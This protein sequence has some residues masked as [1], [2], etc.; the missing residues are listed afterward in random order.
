MLLMSCVCNAFTSVHFCRRERADLLTLVC[1]IY[2]DFVAF[3][4]QVCYLIILIPDPCCLS[5]F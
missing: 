3:L 2:C 4:G 1:D 5:Y